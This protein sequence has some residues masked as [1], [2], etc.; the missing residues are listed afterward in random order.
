MKL[1]DNN[2]DDPLGIYPRIDD[3]SVDM[4]AVSEH[5][6]VTR[7]P[8]LFHSVRS[9]TLPVIDLQGKI[10]GIVSEYDLA[11]V[12][13]DLSINEYSYQCDV[14]VHDIMTKEV[15]TEQKN[16]NIKELFNKLN[17]MHTRV[18]P[19]VDKD[20]YYT[21]NSIT[22]TSIITYI[23]RLIK[24]NSLGGL[25]TPLGVYITDGKHQAGAGNLGLFLTGASLGV[26]LIVI[27]QVFGFAFK[28]FDINTTNAAIF[29]VVFVL[30]ISVFI[31]LL[32]LTPLAKIHAAEHQTINAIEKGL[33]LTLETVKLQPREHVR[34]GTNLMVL[35]IGL[36]LVI[37]TF[38]GYL[39]KIE[40]FFQFI[41]LFGG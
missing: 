34:C 33:P 14:K 24:P 10:I 37:L 17:N 20:N 3:I 40:P 26:M 8:D 23:T 22:R 28:Y 5:C 21:G 13:P 1:F 11:R 31:L 25:A 16:T 32:R 27:E 41:F 29:P 9:D 15:W 7:L 19:I 4:P 30:Q 18:I 36:Q 2:E 35:F 38:V 12:V 6:A 39:S